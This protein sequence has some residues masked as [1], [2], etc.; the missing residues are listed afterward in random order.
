[1]GGVSLVSHVLHSTAATTAGADSVAAGALVHVARAVANR[2]ADVRPK[3]QAQVRSYGCTHA[4]A[5][6]CVRPND[7]PTAESN[8]AEAT[9]HGPAL[10]SAARVRHA[11]QASEMLVLF[12]RHGAVGAYATAEAVLNAS[13][14]L[15]VKPAPAALVGLL[16]TLGSIVRDLLSVPHCVALRCVA[17]RCGPVATYL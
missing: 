4:R 12:G 6:V 2:V 11:M 5:R 17:L 10:A 13:A 9:G 16:T 1:M 3:V 15:G 8:S 14:M 7:A